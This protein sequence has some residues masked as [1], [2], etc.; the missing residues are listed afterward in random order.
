M[1]VC[2]YENLWFALIVSF[3]SPYQ[4][5]HGTCFKVREREKEKKSK[6]NDQNWNK[7]INTTYF[8]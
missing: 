7:S 6:V 2:I 3:F 1:N 8:L 5:P 4:K